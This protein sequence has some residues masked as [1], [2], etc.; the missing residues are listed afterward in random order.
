MNDRKS[1]EPHWRPA[2]GRVCRLTRRE[3]ETFAL[4]FEGLSNASMAERLH[5]TERTVR[6]HVAAVLAKL[7]L[8]SRLAACLASYEFFT[9]GKLACPNES[10]SAEVREIGKTLA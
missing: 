10:R 1:S 4:L 3:Q 8:E 2:L 5:I 6:A 9:K 7:E